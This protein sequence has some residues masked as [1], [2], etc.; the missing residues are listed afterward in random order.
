M[1]ALTG[2]EDDN[3]IPSLAQAYVAQL[4]A[5]GVPAEFRTLEGAGHNFSGLE[6]TVLGALVELAE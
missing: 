5:R 1:I 4:Q 2:T 3:T 6:S